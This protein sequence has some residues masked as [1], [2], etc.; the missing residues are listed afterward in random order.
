MN[1]FF[2]RLSAFA[3]ITASCLAAS[4]A[5]PTAAGAAATDDVFI[6][7]G[8]SVLAGFDPSTGGSYGG[9]GAAC[10]EA[11]NRAL[12]GSRSGDCRWR[13][14]GSLPGGGW[15]GPATGCYLIGTTKNTTVTYFWRQASDIDSCVQGKGCNANT[16]PVWQSA[17]CLGGGNTTILWGNVAANKQVKVKSLSVVTGSKVEWE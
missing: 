1:L 7:M 9:D 4:I 6:P 5:V 8:T 13:T 10:A 15:S 11:T 12:G 14:A 17:G 3:V 2:F 16:A